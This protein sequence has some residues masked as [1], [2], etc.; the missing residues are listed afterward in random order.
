MRNPARTFLEWYRSPEQFLLR[1]EIAWFRRWLLRGWGLL[2]VVISFLM[3][4]PSSSVGF[5]SQGAMSRCQTV[6]VRGM[7]S[8]E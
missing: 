2:F 6:S 4:L 8:A 1:I 5:S 3:G 7:E